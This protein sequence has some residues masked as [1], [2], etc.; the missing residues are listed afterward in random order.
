MLDS[1]DLAILGLLQENS[2]YQWKEIGEK[3]HLTGP[4]VSLRVQAMQDAGVIENFTVSLDDA[5]LGRPFLAF[6]SVFMASANHGAFHRFIREQSAIVE[7]HRVSGEGCYWLRARL[8]S[9]EELN[10]LLEDILHHGNYR[11]SLAIDTLKDSGR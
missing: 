7:A 5:K 8:A 11:L 10:R 4:A 1:T 2:R 9:Q 3:V 6:I